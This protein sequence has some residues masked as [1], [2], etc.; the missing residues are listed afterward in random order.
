M[1]LLHGLHTSHFPVYLQQPTPVK[2]TKTERAHQRCQGESTLFGIYAREYRD[3][4]N[5]IE[6]K[7]VKYTPNTVPI[8][9]KTTSFVETVAVLT[10]KILHLKQ[11]EASGYG[12]LCFTYV[13]S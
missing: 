11:K 13:K 10:K 4:T 1:G 5:F 6:R 12:I 9:N 3:V 2:R 8:S 7:E